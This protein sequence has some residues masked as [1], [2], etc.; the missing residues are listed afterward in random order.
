MPGDVSFAHNA[1]EP[2]PLNNRESAYLVC[3]HDG[4]HVGDV[5]VRVD[6]VDGA[7][8]EF[9]GGGGAGIATAS[10]AL[11]HDVAIGDHPVQSVV[12]ATDGQR[13]NV[14][15]AHVLGSSSQ[16]FVVADTCHSGVHDLFGARHVNSL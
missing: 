9:T 10:D 5:G 13:A 8:G 12:V 16:G 4:E 3:L 14:E 2:L 11:D 1:Y 6:L 15:V 7:L